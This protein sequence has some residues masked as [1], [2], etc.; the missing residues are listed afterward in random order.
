MMRCNSGNSNRI[1]L[2]QSSYPDDEMNE[3]ESQLIDRLKDLDSSFSLELYLSREIERLESRNSL[4]YKI[5]EI[6]T[7][8][9]RDATYIVNLYLSQRGSS[10]KVLI[11]VHRG[12]HIHP[13]TSTIE[14]Q[15]RSL[16]MCNIT[17]E[18]SCNT[19]SVNGMIPNGSR[20]ELLESL[21]L[22]PQ[23]SIEDHRESNKNFTEA[24]M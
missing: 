19:W 6:F 3:I 4:M 15:L 18:W 7:V 5:Y 23:I 13:H 21:R 17:S 24:I 1:Q 10:V 12:L 8:Y 9:R 2:Y 16:G 22:I 11:S 20:D 14:A